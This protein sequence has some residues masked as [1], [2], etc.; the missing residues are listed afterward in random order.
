[1]AHVNLR[2]GSRGRVGPG[3]SLDR[4]ID[5]VAEIK[6]K[7]NDN[8]MDLTFNNGSIQS[9]SLLG[10]DSISFSDVADDNKDYT[11]QISD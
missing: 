2:A 7:P 5:D 11:I 9:F 10:I 6:F 4:K 1:M 8:S 3:F